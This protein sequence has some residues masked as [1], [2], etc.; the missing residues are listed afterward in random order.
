MGSQ[1]ARGS[2]GPLAGLQLLKI[3]A[4][5]AVGHGAAW[6]RAAGVCHAVPPRLA[7]R[8]RPLSGAFAFQG[9]L[10]GLEEELLAFFSVTPHSVYTALMDNRYHTLPPGCGWGHPT[11]G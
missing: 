6:G 2:A 9:T 8:L 5:V 3:T 10:E 11:G 1:R 4:P 7:P